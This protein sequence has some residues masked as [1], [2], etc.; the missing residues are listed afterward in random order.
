MSVLYYNIY[1]LYIYIY[2]MIYIYDNS[3]LSFSDSA[4]KSV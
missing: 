3:A 2:D 4:T 1:M